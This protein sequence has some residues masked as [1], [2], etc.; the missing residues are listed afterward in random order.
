MQNFDAQEKDEVIAEHDAPEPQDP[1]GDPD[2]TS[3]NPDDDDE[4]GDASNPGDGRSLRARKAAASVPAAPL[5]SSG[6]GQTSST[7]APNQGPGRSL[8]DAVSAAESR[9]RQIIPGRAR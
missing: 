3:K 4:Q 7:R 6:A 1:T 9:V 5:G 8:R 2:P